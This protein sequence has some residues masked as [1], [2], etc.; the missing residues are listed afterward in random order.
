MGVPGHTTRNAPAELARTE[1]FAVDAYLADFDA[2]VVAADHDQGR[3]ALAR[4][5]FFPGGGGQPHDVGTLRWDGGSAPVTKVKRDGE[6]LWHW[7]DA[8][9]VPTV[10]TEVAGSIDWPRRHLTMR[11]HTALHILCGVLWSEF[12]LPVTGGNME[13]GKGRLDFPLEGITTEFGSLLERRIN[14]EIERAR[15]IVVDFVGRDD[16]DSDPALIRTAANLI[17]REIDPLRVI[18]IVGLDKQADGGTHVVSTAEVRRV[19]VTKT[20]SKGKAN[21]RV[22][23]EVTD[24][25]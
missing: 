20:E 1:L 4:T 10:G 16:A 6:H 17:P 25:D 21:K 14:D 15:E 22:R 19:V 11:T 9:E 7:V 3:V 12:Q 13:P 24:H 2:T 5:A 23:L 8:P 18:D